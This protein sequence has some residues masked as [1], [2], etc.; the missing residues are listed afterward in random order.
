M[1]PVHVQPIIMVYGLTLFF[2]GSVLWSRTQQWA[3]V[4]GGEPIRWMGWFGMLSGVA[5]LTHI[6]GKEGSQLVALQVLH[7]AINA[8]AFTALWFVALSKPPLSFSITLQKRLR[9]LPLFG[10]MS[11]FGVFAL[12]R[13]GLL[14]ESWPV[15]AEHLF[16]IIP[17]SVTTGFLLMRYPT[18]VSEEGWQVKPIKRSGILLLAFGVFQLFS[19]AF[20]GLFFS[21]ALPTFV[22]L[23]FHLILLITIL[24]LSRMFLRGTNKPIPKTLSPEEET[25]RAVIRAPKPEIKPAPT[26]VDPDIS[27]LEE[28]SIIFQYEEEDARITNANQRAANLWRSTTNALIDTNFSQLVTPVGEQTSLEVADKVMTDILNGHKI[29]IKNIEILPASGA[30]F[31]VDLVGI[32]L[33]YN[34]DQHPL[35]QL[36]FWESGTLF[37]IESKDG[38]TTQK[39]I[40][41]ITEKIPEPAIDSK[42]L[43]TPETEPLSEQ[44]SGLQESELRHRTFFH[45]SGMPFF[46]LDEEGGLLHFNQSLRLMTGHSRDTL[47]NLTWL[48]LFPEKNHEKSQALLDR[49]ISGDVD[50]IHEEAPLLHQSGA[51]LW[52]TI[53]LSVL[54][55][56]TG[57]IRFLMG[58]LQDLTRRKKMEKVF[59][60]HHDHLDQKVKQQVKLLKEAGNRIA[61]QDIR[62]E[63]L[64]ALMT[65]L[66][67][68]VVILDTKTACRMANPAFVRFIKKTAKEILGQPLEKILP[69]TFAEA[70]VPLIDQ[71][72]TGTR[73]KQWHTLR[74]S[75]AEKPT[76]DLLCQPF[77]KK[78]QGPGGLVVVFAPQHI[79]QVAKEPVIELSLDQ[80]ETPEL[81]LDISPGFAREMENAPVRLQTPSEPLT[82]DTTE[83]DAQ[84]EALCHFQT[85][86][87]NRFFDQ[88]ELQITP[89]ARDLYT[90]LKNGPNVPLD[91][92]QANA[93]LRD[94]L[95]ALD[96]CH[97]AFPSKSDDP[98]FAPF[99][100]L[101]PIVNLVS[102]DFKQRGI[103]LRLLPFEQSVEVSGSPQILS[104]VLLTIL[105]QCR[106]T[107]LNR[108]DEASE[109]AGEVI[110]SMSARNNEAIIAIRDNGPRINPD[111][112]IKPL[113]SQQNPER[114]HSVDLPTARILVSEGLD[115]TL[116]V[117]NVIGGVEFRIQL[118]IATA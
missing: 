82:V 60:Y 53:Y 54:R 8:L 116:E 107:L 79:Q 58:Q 67:H 99:E 12:T 46:F 102:A 1:I 115:G 111:V 28:A 59:Q 91:V 89:P 5:V 24:V 64:H 38:D 83:S 50:Q 13:L 75:D 7:H 103:A 29:I 118:P 22:H 110:L 72:L 48:D 97:S 66:P 49:V 40:D 25:V 78:E 90:M 81:D 39:P 17:A 71:G 20:L 27:H 6:L 100:I 98:V 93:H 30:S 36:I 87:M 19:P 62:L 61:K 117:V 45:R 56:E 18:L 47:K 63:R 108:K 14:S 34:D 94:L 42:S 92:Q 4:E 9:Y 106:D 55:N 37:P 88:L 69:E 31:H 35:F 85:G 104:Q 3:Q 2:F 70:I 41:T 114:A 77:G 52:V 43:Q 95:M 109:L 96:R 44:N 15:L 57:Q 10:L 21:N 11:W 73:M 68:A 113:E 51:V 80:E 16:L 26:M 23:I 74:S 112:L 76:M 105:E 84:I 101:Q 65:S 32:Q 86:A 33:P